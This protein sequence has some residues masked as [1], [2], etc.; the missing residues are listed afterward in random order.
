MNQLDLGPGWAPLDFGSDDDLG[1]VRIGQSGEDVIVPKTALRRVIE[2][3]EAFEKK[4][5]G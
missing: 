1:C 2:T 4:L 3:L 5:S